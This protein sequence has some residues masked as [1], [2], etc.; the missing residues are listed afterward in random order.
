VL[1]AIATGG[2]ALPPDVR[3]DLEARLG[4]DFSAVRIHTGDAAARSADAL[5]AEAYTVGDDIVF[6]RGAFAP[7]DPLGR[8][9]LA[10]EL[11]HVLQ[12]R[13]GAASS[14]GVSD[15]ADPLERAAEGT[16][17]TALAGPRPVGL[18]LRI[19]DV[20]TAPRSRIIQR[21]AVL[22]RSPA[23]EAASDAAAESPWLGLTA[24]GMLD[25]A[26][27]T[28][29]V[30]PVA[31]V[32]TPGASAAG[33]AS[34]GQDERADPNELDPLARPRR[35]PPQPARSAPAPAEPSDEAARAADHTAVQ[36]VAAT[37]EAFSEQ[38]AADTP[39]TDEQQPE[40]AAIPEAVSDEAAEAGAPGQLEPGGPD[41]ATELK[42]PEFPDETAEEFFALITADRQGQRALQAAVN[43]ALADVATMMSGES[44]RIDAD[45]RTAE[46]TITVAVRA[47]RGRVQGA[48]ASA[49]TRVD[50]ARTDQAARVTQQLDRKKSSA[51]TEVQQIARDVE[52]VGSRRADEAQRVG[53]DAAADLERSRDGYLPTARRKGNEAAASANSDAEEPEIARASI[54][55]QRQAAHEVAEQTAHAIDDAMNASARDLRGGGPEFHRAVAGQLQPV[56]RDIRSQTGPIERSLTATGTQL[57]TTLDGGGT[58]AL[59]SIEATT[60]SLMDALTRVDNQTKRQL[61]T[62]A[63]TTKAGLRHAQ[64]DGEQQLRDKAAEFVHTAHGELQQQL[65]LVSARPVRRMLARRLANELSSVLRS[66]YGVGAQ[67]ANQIAG[68]IAAQ[69]SASLAQ[70]HQELTAST[71]TAASGT[72]NV[73][74]SAGQQ[75]GQL[76][77]HVVDFLSRTVTGALVQVDTAQTERMTRLGETVGVV[78]QR[79]QPFVDQ[80]RIRVNDDKGRANQ[81]ATGKLGTLDSRTDEAMRKAR[82]KAEYGAFGSWLLDQLRSL[83]RALLTPSFW[84]GLLVGL[85]I[86]IFIIATFGSGAVVLIVAGVVAGAISAAA[87]YTAQVYL[88]PLVDPSAPH[89]EFNPREMGYQMLIGGIAGGI[90][91]A[92][93]GLATAGVNAIVTNVASR[94]VVNKAAQTVVGAALGAVQNCMTG[95]DGGVH[96]QWQG[97]RWDE[98]LLTNLAVSTAMSSR[99]VEEHIQGIQERARAGM[100]ERGLARNVTPAESE[101]AQAR[102]AA[103]P[104][105]TDTTG[106]RPTA[107][108]A[109]DLSGVHVDAVPAGPQVPTPAEPYPVAPPAEPHVAGPAAPAETRPQAEVPARPAAP[110][111]A[112]PTPPTE[113]HPPAEPVAAAPQREGTPRP[114]APSEERP[115]GSAPQE[116]QVIDLPEHTVMSGETPMTEHEARVMYENS[117]S[118]TPHNEVGIFRNS[119]TGEHIVI[120]GNNEFVDSRTS[121]N[122]ALREFMESRPG[123]T[124]QWELIEHSHPVDPTRGV[125]HEAQRL[126]SGRN[127]DYDVARAESIARGGQPV[128]QR[129]GIVTERGNETVTYGYDPN[130]AQPYSLTYPGPDGQPVSRRFKSMEAYGEWYENHPGTSGG[131]P[132]IEGEGGVASAPGR[133]PRAGSRPEGGADTGPGRGAAVEPPPNERAR[134]AIPAAAGEAATAPRER[135]T[136]PPLEE[137]GFVHPAREAPPQPPDLARPTGPP[138][139]PPAPPVEHQPPSAPVARLEE[140]AQATV[141]EPGPG[142]RAQATVAEPR[143]EEHAAATAPP[144][145]TATAVDAVANA[146][147]RELPAD[148]PGTRRDKNGRL[149][150]PDGQFVPDPRSE[151][152]QEIHYFAEK[153]ETISHDISAAGAEDFH[154]AQRTREELQGRN[155]AARERVKGLAKEHGIEPG[156]L[157]HSDERQATLQ[158]LRMQGVSAQERGELLHAEQARV[159][160]ANRLNRQSERLGMLAGADVLHSDGF[161]PVSGSAQVHGGPGEADLVGVS[162]GGDRMRVVEA[163]GG[164]ADLGAGR[165]MEDTGLRAQQGSPE[166]LN[167]LLH[168]DPNF[169]QYL[170]DNPEFARKLANGQVEIEYRLVSARGDGTIRVTTLRLD[171]RQV[172]QLRLSDLA[173]ATTAR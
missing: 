91:A 39:V 29:T 158:R 162:R 112:R 48:A 60:R 12:Q 64:S 65:Q 30:T 109:P 137:P 25:F 35:E 36:A 24:P 141:A 153:G 104:G 50:R 135:A 32:P 87:A 128:E 41:G 165:I 79:L 77:R 114:A 167:D 6:A 89:R 55:A 156:S 103:G 57:A 107:T 127:G 56:V 90:G 146:Q 7:H 155:T 34:A 43:R 49:R 117:R 67:Q 106:P 149:R 98:G 61:R 97:E 37:K 148:P 115:P 80:T 66:G 120:Q 8:L 119:E 70:F 126:P 163:K 53:A 19:A 78:D 84:V 172:S 134:A 1:S 132:H 38:P 108:V 94:V 82:E 18:A 99:R 14:P 54:G 138:A 23:R 147:G 45:V 118:E 136:P 152:R 2:A 63:E 169:Q 142:E 123:Q 161:T 154:D 68:R 151:A 75:L 76:E 5:A 140:S 73:A 15:P 100:V 59:R 92:A 166:Y 125:T 71:Q 160:A 105:V 144:E 74:Q 4:A 113:A 139:Q 129:I 81:D 124:G 28:P 88:D 69:L 20:P 9:R 121:R 133:R 62:A 17:R 46:D 159:R 10:H 145:P 22:E 164:S 173:P 11:T 31:N 3:A 51:G 150:G 21:R 168:R 171:T 44:E 143:P 85:L 13:S 111:P 42:L 83:G 40:A 157:V 110:E 96:W 58:N 131:S 52:N 93:G 16:A 130:Q 95:P 102:R 86:T 33:A 72:E 26:D 116:P 170:K 27:S 101:R 122:A 47:A